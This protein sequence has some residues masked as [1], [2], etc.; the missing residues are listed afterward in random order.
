MQA[1]KLTDLMS[2]DLITEARNDPN[3]THLIIL[4]D[5]A[6]GLYFGV[7]A[8]SPEEYRA[9]FNEV[10]TDRGRVATVSSIVFLNKDK[11]NKSISMCAR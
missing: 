4:R 6:T 8:S 1:S 2:E 9:I 7:P 11:T 5:T 10:V 3:H